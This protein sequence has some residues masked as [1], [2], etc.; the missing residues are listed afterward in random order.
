MWIFSWPTH[1]C[2][3]HCNENLIYVFF[4]GN[5]AASVPISKV[6]C[7]WAIYIFSGSVYI[8]PAAEQTD[9]LW[10]YINRAQTHECGNWDCGRPI[11]FL[12]IF[13]SNFRYWFSAVQFGAFTT[14]A[15]GPDAWA[16]AQVSCQSREQTALPP[17][18]HYPPYG[19]NGNTSS[20]HFRLSSP[21]WGDAQDAVLFVKGYFLKFQLVWIW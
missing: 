6:M 3:P 10:D 21:L 5:C 19:G 4:S 11:P 16:L 7:Q 14:A 15:C 13:V 18:P 12:G 17:P 1:E 9:R 2:F 20:N 8:F